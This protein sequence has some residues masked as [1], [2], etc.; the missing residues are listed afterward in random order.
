MSKK[1][2]NMAA[3]TN[4]LQGASLFFSKPVPTPP[5]AKKQPQPIAPK[6]VK[7]ARAVELEA[8]NQ[9]T[10]IQT[11]SK[12]SRYHAIKQASYHD[13]TI[14]LIRKA[15]R[16]IGKDAFFGRFTPEEKAMLSDA[17]YT[18]KRSGVKTSENEIVR[19]AVNFIVNDYQENGENSLL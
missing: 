14:E 16:F 1:I 17:A 4:E 13:S 19:I 10:V 15:V 8:E 2:L 5:V 6:P 3:I 9:A 18:Y 11:D 12:L 7:E